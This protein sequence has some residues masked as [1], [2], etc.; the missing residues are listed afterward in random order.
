MQETKESERT[1]YAPPAISRSPFARTARGRGL[2][3]R[4]SRPSTHTAF[5]PSAVGRRS[6]TV[7][8]SSAAASSCSRAVGVGTVSSSISHTYSAIPGAAE[9]LATAY[10]MPAQNPPAP[11]VFSRSSRIYAGIGVRPAKSRATCKAPSVLALSTMT[12]ESGLRVCALSADR[13]S[14]SNPARLYDTTT[15]VTEYCIPASIGDVW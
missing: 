14:S 9:P 13:H 15:A 12:S 8:H 4:C 10:A 2:F 11:P 3:I 1:W 7:T 5:D 6:F